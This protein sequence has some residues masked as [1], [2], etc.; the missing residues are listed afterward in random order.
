MRF[1]DKLWFTF[2]LFLIFFNSMC[3]RSIE[4]TQNTMAKKKTT[5]MM[6][7]LVLEANYSKKSVG[8]K[9]MTIQ[10][11]FALTKICEILDV[12]NC[13]NEM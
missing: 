6:M 11:T 2:I 4:I 13:P 8:P 1:A 3:T 10:L 12:T 5:V 9:C 7:K